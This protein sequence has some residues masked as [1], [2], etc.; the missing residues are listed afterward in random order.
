MLAEALKRWATENGCRIAWGP[1]SVLDDIRE[2]LSNRA[3]SGE[4]DPEFHDEWLTDFRYPNGTEGTVI[5]AAF[6]QPGRKA[7][8]ET[9]EGRV[10]A[11]IPPTY[12]ETIGRLNF[13]EKLFDDIPE[14]R[15]CLEAL[16]VP[17]K[18]TAAR[19]GLVRYGRNNI[20]YVDRF[21]SYFQLAGFLVA[22]NWKPYPGRKA[23][24]PQS[25]P[26]CESCD[27]CIG[28]CPTGAISDDRFL[29]QAHRCLTY[30][31]EGSKPWPEDLPASAHHCL[32]G[33]MAC[34]EACPLNAGMLSTVDSGVVFTKDETDA[35]LEDEVW[36]SVKEKLR[37]LQVDHYAQVLGRNLR[38]LL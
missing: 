27:L 24:R 22:E 36:P 21:G 25:V 29:I 38:A 16:Y 33:C 8:F 23:Y 14:A 32:V 12:G 10:E 19:F 6:P 26:E 11:F 9:G 18:S 30:H 17:L 4:L 7:V 15:E 13:S 3:S 34:Q 31:N 5:V 35:A 1:A 28:A 20:T 37:Q 2:E